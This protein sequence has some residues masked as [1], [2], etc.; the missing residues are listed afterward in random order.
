MLAE[1]PGLTLEEAA[2]AEEALRACEGIRPDLV[3]LDIR[4]GDDPRDRAGLDVLRRLRAA[5]NAVPVVMVTSLTEVT[6]VREAMRCGAQDYVFKDELAPELLV[7][8]VQSVRHR[9]GVRRA[10]LGAIVDRGDLSAH[11]AAPE[12]HP[13]AGGHGCD[14]ADSG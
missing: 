9:A 1:I 2:S 13:A 11:G 5:G 12:H 10:L 3:L 7:P 6:E 8:V 4:L 14:G